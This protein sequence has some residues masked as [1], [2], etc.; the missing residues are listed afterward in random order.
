VTTKENGNEKT[1]SDTL[2]LTKRD[3]EWKIS[4]L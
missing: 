1:E 3:G 4:T 2:Q